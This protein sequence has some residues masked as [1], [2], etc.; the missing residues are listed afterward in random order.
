MSDGAGGI[1]APKKLFFE[2]FCP[3]K[4]QTGGACKSSVKPQRFVNAACRSV[5]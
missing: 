5:T 3:K 4:H 2:R 1:T